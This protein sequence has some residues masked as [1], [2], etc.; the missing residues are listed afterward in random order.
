M[1]YRREAR[2]AWRAGVNA[3]LVNANET[4]AT[5]KPCSKLLRPVPHE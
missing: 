2:R 1:T 5:L 3:P 4:L